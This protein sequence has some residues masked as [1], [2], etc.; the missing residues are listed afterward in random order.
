L[1][2]TPFDIPISGVSME[3]YTLFLT[4]KQS[5]KVAIQARKRG[6]FGDLSVTS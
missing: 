4:E 3:M 6:L 2:I 1:I 5:R